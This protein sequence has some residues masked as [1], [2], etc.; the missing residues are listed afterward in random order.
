MY[1]CFFWAVGIFYP[2]TFNAALD[3]TIK[4]KK[5]QKKK[6]KKQGDLAASVVLPTTGGMGWQR[7]ICMLQNSAKQSKYLIIEQSGNFMK[8]FPPILWFLQNIIT[9]T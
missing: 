8:L 4:F 6:Q 5:D 7:Q 3:C 9:W 1:A 2:L